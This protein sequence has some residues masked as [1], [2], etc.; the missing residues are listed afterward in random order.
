MSVPFNDERLGAAFKEAV[1]VIEAME[2]VEFED[3][4]KEETRQEV[5]HYMKSK[6][7]ALYPYDCEDYYHKNPGLGDGKGSVRSKDS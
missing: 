1:V 7:W 6:I 5:L 2:H 4:A 3:P